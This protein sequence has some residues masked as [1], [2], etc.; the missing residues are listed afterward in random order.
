MCAASLRIST[1]IQYLLYSSYTSVISDEPQPDIPSPTTYNIDTPDAAN[2][3]LNWRP[4]WLRRVVLVGFMAI[5]ASI[6]AAIESLLGVSS[7]RHGLTTSTSSEHY[8]W[9]YGPTAFLT[10]LSALWSRTEFQSK[11]VAPWIRLSRK[12]TP[13]SR[14]L[15]LDYISQLQPFAIFRALRSK[16][17][18]VSIATT[19]SI[20]IKVLI[21]ISTSL[22]SLS[23]ETVDRSFSMVYRDSFIDSNAKLS[24]TGNLAYY[25]LESMT[26]HD[27][28]LPDG[29]S[30]EYA[31]QSVQTNL[32]DTTETRVIVDGLTNSL[33]CWPVELR[34][35][36][37][38]LPMLNGYSTFNVSITSP[39]CEVALVSLS[40]VLPDHIMSSQESRD[41]SMLFGRFKQIQCDGIDSDAGKR[42]LV[43]FGNVTYH[44][45]YSHM[46]FDG[47]GH[48][49]PSSVSVLE[50]STQLFCVP[51]YAIHEVEVTRNGTQNFTIQ[52]Q[53][54]AHNR[55]L[56]SVTAWDLL[57]AQFLA[58]NPTS[59]FPISSTSRTLGMD[60]VDLVDGYLNAGFLAQL[61]TGTKA[62]SLF[63]PKFLQQSV[64][65]YYRL[66]G[67]IVAKQSLMHLT[68]TNFIGSATVNEFRLKVHNRI[69]H[70]MVILITICFILVGL[71]IFIIPTKCSL[72]QNPST[73]L[74]LALLFSNSPGLL[75]QLRNAGAYKSEDLAHY[76]GAAKFQSIVPF[77]LTPTS[78]GEYP[79]QFPQVSSKPYNPL[80]LRTACRLVVC[81]TLSNV[82]DGLSDIEGDTYIQYA[83]SVLPALTVGSLAVAL[84]A[85]DFETRS[86]APYAMLARKIATDKFARLELL[87]SMIPK[88]IWKEAR[89][90]SIWL[91]ATTTAFLIA[92]FFTTFSASI[93]QELSVLT[94]TS[95]TIQ[96]T[97]S[98]SL[99]VSPHV[100]YSEVP[101]LIF[102]AN[103]S[104][105]KFTYKN[106]A[107]PQ[108]VPIT[109]SLDG[110]STFNKSTV[111][112]TT[113]IPALRDRMTCRTYNSAQIRT[114][115]D[116]S[117][118][119][120]LGISIDAEDCGALFDFGDHS[121]VRM[122]IA[123]NTT[124]FGMERT[125]ATT[126]SV[127]VGCSDLIY[128][129]GKIDH[130]PKLVIQHIAAAACND[131]FEAVDVNVTFIGTTLDFDSQNPPQPLEGTVRNSTY[132]AV[133]NATQ[134]SAF[135]GN[136][137]IHIDVSPAL[138]D[139]FFSTT[140]TSPWAI[141]I[142]ALGDP[143]A[144]TNVADAIELHR[145]IYMAQ[146]LAQNLGPAN[147]TNA[148]VAEFHTNP[149]EP[150]SNDASL[151]RNTT[152]TAAVGRRRIVQ[153]AASTH[154]LVALLATTLTLLIIGWLTGP[155]TSILPR[156]PTSVGSVMALV[157]GG[158]LLG[159]MP[160]DAHLRSPEK[161]G[162]ALGG[163]ETGLWIGWGTLPDEEGIL[164]GGENEGGVSRFGI[165]VVDKEEMEL[166]S[167]S[168]PWGPW[169]RLVNIVARARGRNEPS[170]TNDQNA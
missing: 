37:V 40:G 15:L 88:V 20:I 66:I 168:D 8:L 132:A 52:P 86:L 163:T 35:A 135:Y 148:L 36:T 113:V 121:L 6:I 44:L 141:P 166:T 84:S 48:P 49:W 25:L 136:S 162:A 38:T 109:E 120:T 114:K 72:P 99:S 112:I 89:F 63:E 127:I 156:R 116:S 65:A 104:F 129:W 45:D 9:T 2:Q 56:N 71:M 117:E 18:A 164:Y 26:S 73:V 83:W 102:G 170:R 1:Y 138:M 92:S 106:L 161:V 143:S 155:P 93:F 54:A 152:V 94:K 101:S 87:D 31:F 111:S 42:V 4:L 95:M 133:L 98:F 22:I 69:A 70:G 147:E 165:F 169:K 79:R 76:L 140:V 77:E 154:I 96:A 110:S 97:Q 134:S 126:P 17:F 47:F 5:F 28:S 153:D 90:K 27:L 124:Y 50:K 24:T 60:P 62:S 13:A 100:G 167:K 115:V 160:A 128:V 3:L 146:L 51:T 23:L 80:I 108:F 32:P 46:V 7:R 57:E 85:I 67:A 149:V 119:Y 81:F 53:E 150:D 91:L 74:G 145:G 58:T 11:L 59:G 142:S 78:D 107:F 122:P 68:P 21:V 137:L 34:S 12:P 43:I 39:G 29:I 144:I 157:A 123:D 33:D 131:S 16:D 118:P 41:T 151:I 82:Q 139:P 10:I 125:S 55:S 159:R 64:T 61:D 30:S 75:A 14:T 105:P 158:N 19:V 130:N 103:Y